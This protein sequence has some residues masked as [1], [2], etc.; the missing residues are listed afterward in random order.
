MS[1]SAGSGGFRSHPRAPCRKA[2]HSGGLDR[3][4]ALRICPW[5]CKSSVISSGAAGRPHA[6]LNEGAADR[7]VPCGAGRRP[8]G[9]LPGCGRLQPHPRDEGRAGYRWSVP[10]G[11]GQGRLQALPDRRRTRHPARGDHHRRQPQRRHPTDPAD[12]GRSVV[13]P[14]RGRRGR[15][16]RRPKHLYADRGYD[17][18]VYRDKV[19]RVPDRP[20]PHPGPRPAR[21]RAR[22]RPGCVPLGRG[23]SDRTAALLR[24]VRIRWEIRDDIHHAF[25]TLGCAVICRRRLR[26]AL[27]WE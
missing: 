16:L 3:A 11:P 27:C 2:R 13:P 19:R 26:T 25:V 1:C 6:G 9:F 20:A 23:R 14:I 21:H 7:H 10:G 12:P 24:R 4:V 8:A 17:H 15:P 18:E 5:R 22:L